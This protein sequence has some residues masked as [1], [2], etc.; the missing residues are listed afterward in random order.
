MNRKNVLVFPCGSEIG[1]EI[2]RSLVHSRFV[3]LFGAS[4][5]PDHGRFVFKN[6]IPDIPFYNEINFIES[7]RTII[8]QNK[9]D[10]IYP[11]M[12]SLIV[13]LKRNEQKLDCKVISSPLETVETCL[14]KRKTY[15]CMDK[16][17]SVPLVYDSV[18]S[19]DL[20][21]VFLKPDVGYGSRGVYIARN[22]EDLLY[23]L[24]KDP[25]LLMLEY[26]PGKEFTIDCF[27]G[28]NGNLIF[29]GPRSRERVV[30]GISVNTKPAHEIYDKAY[31]IAQKIN[32][33]LKFQGAW[34][35]QLKYNSENEL[36]LLEIAS[37]LAGSSSLFRNKG[38]NF[39]LMSLFDSF[40]TENQI[41]QNNYTIELDR[42]L[43]NS[44]RCDIKYSTIYVDYDDCLI[45]DGKVNFQLV[46]FLFSAMN[47]SN[48]IILLTKHAGDLQESLLKYKLSGIFDKIVHLLPLEEKVDYIDANEAIFID[49]S[50]SERKKVSKIRGIPVFSPDMVECLL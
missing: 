29:V 23:A 43:G 19:I 45:I 5:V 32:T 11:A 16:L 24:K 2:H 46:S 44:Y 1:L 12:D 15:S 22:R 37:R 4:S 33:R 20:F 3:N 34:F 42:A 40:G 28:A 38:I 27:T 13:E 31:E 36:T 10:A 47:N 21:P 49:D 18:E 9:I 50:F 7:L 25:T 39:A 48:R 6:F 17:V 30:N 8:V 14:S 35:F 26:L 41:L